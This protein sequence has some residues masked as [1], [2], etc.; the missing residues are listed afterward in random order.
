MS[1]IWNISLSESLPSP[2]TANDS[3][4]SSHSPIYGQMENSSSDN[5][6]EPNLT[7]DMSTS[8]F[9]ADR[10]TSRDTSPPTLDLTDD[11]WQLALEES[12]RNELIE[13]E[14]ASIRLFCEDVEHN[15]AEVG[16]GP[17][18]NDSVLRNI[19]SQR[20]SIPE[21][22]NQP[23][24][25]IDLSN[26]EFNPIPRSAR[27]LAPDAIIDLCSPEPRRQ[28]PT[29]INLADSNEPQTC[30][31][32]RRLLDTS[33]DQPVVVEEVKAAGVSPPKQNRVEKT[34]P[35]DESYKC[36][37]CLDSVRKREP[38]STRCGH[39]FCKSCILTAVQST[40]K[41]PLCNKKVTQRS[42]FRIYL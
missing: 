40:H 39:I 13:A 30:V 22:T 15:L 2:T 8:S 27:S 23:V 9:N 5:N 29:Y 19:L 1:G 14:I 38:S 25:L 32:R 41:C 21:T 3:I 12:L 31:R 6:S 34:E 16:L 18:G 33:S 24:D 26:I 28:L 17:E 37:V 7:P 35:C 36:P 10:P 4:V 42:I 11:G 20:N